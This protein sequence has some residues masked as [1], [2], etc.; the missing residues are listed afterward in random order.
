MAHFASMCCSSPLNLQVL[1][2]D[3]HDN[4]FD[5]RSLNILRRHNIQY[6][7]L[8]AD[9]SVHDQSNDNG[10]KMNLKNFYG[11]A[12][13]NWMRH[14]G[15]LKF[16]LPHMN[17]ILVETWV[18]FKLS[19]VTITHKYSKNTHILTLTPPEKGTNHQIYLACT[20][21]SNR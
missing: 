6:F 4:H 14:H 15:T 1:F 5:D 7:I 9:D 11:N 3:G 18:A 10:P 12:R 8:K 16:I 13:M 17:N 21:M 20:Q 2:Y 19:S